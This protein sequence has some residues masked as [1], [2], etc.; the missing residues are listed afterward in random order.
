M[1]YSRW[2]QLSNDVVLA[3]PKFGE[4]IELTC[5][6]MKKRL[7]LPRCS[8]LPTPEPE[9]GSKKLMGEL[10]LMRESCE[11]S[12]NML[13]IGSFSTNSDECQDPQLAGTVR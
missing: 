6:L 13:Y 7:S 11:E 2:A 4:S 5:E 3:N 1:P 9:D 8:P 12:L 10:R